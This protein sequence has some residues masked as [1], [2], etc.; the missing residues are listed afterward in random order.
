ML[1]IME[2]K[3]RLFATVATAAVLTAAVAPVSA[4]SLSSNSRFA[5]LLNPAVTQSAPNVADKQLSQVADAY[6]L[7]AEGE[8]KE[9]GAERSADLDNQAADVLEGKVVDAELRW[10][11]GLLADDGSWTSG[12]THIIDAA[13]NTFVVSKE[14]HSSVKDSTEHKTLAGADEVDGAYGLAV[15]EDGEDIYAVVAVG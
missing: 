6:Q 12:V 8:L 13:G 5:N 7:W 9:T 11:E 4:A 10:E 3:S 14:S 1:R 15:A 2:I